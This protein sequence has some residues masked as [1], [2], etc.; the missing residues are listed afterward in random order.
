MVN[1]IDSGTC[2]LIYE[3]AL[4]TAI[5][6]WIVSAK[7]DPC[8]TLTVRGSLQRSTQSINKETMRI[9]EQ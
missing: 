2:A 6:D 1:T 3:L 9:T 5:L 8:P 4:I 7:I